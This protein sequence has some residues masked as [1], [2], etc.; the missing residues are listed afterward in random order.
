[1]LTQEKNMKQETKQKFKTIGVLGGM[2]HCASAHFYQ[3]LLKSAQEKLKAV[4]DDEYPQIIINSIAL[5]GGTEYGMEK[6]KSILKQLI[7]GLKTLEKAGADFLVIPCNSVHNSINELRRNTEVP[8][9]S[10]I[11]QVGKVVQDSSSKKILILSSE[12]T[13]KYGL[14]SD[15]SGSGIQLIKPSPELKKKVTKLILSVM[16][17]KNISKFKK[18]VVVEINTLYKSKKIDSV[19]LGC[20]ELPVAITQN[21]TNAKTYDSLKILA[22]AGMR[23]SK[24]L[25]I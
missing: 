20:T 23:F 15:L 10:I 4:Q 16:G 8:I 2:G 24:G 7:N 19:I 6:N 11:E 18:P 25:D 9:L 13:S 3:L 12:T 17:N 1:V 21:D 22:D 14:Y 5:E